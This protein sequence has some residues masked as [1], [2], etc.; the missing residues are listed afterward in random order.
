MENFNFNKSFIFSPDQHNSVQMSF[1]FFFFFLKGQYG[2]D[3]QGMESER[4]F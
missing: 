1:L 4:L 2:H 3:Q